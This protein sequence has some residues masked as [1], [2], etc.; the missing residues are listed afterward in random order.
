MQNELNLKHA[1]GGAMTA[2]PDVQTAATEVLRLLREIHAAVV[3]KVEEEPKPERK[4]R[5]HL[6]APILELMADGEGRA[7]Y[8][9]WQ[10]LLRQHIK[11]TEA[12]VNAQ[13]TTLKKEGKLVRPRKNLYYL[14]GLEPKEETE[15]EQ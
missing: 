14:T 7:S 1:G 3:P 11:C 2:N 4:K 13:M 8:V 12:G 6:G 9:I 5:F 15:I 10:A